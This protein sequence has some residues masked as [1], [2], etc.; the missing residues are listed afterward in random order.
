MALCIPEESVSLSALSK[1]DREAAVSWGDDT[2]TS[3]NVSLVNVISHFKTSSINI[4][5]I[6]VPSY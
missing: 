5:V 1:T 3:K 2:N 6:R 4:H